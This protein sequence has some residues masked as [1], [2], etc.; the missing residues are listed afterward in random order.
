MPTCEVCHHSYSVLPG[1]LLA[2]AYSKHLL[3]CRRREYFEM[4]RIEPGRYLTPGI[5]NIKKEY[6]ISTIKPGA[7]EGIIY[8]I[9]HPRID[10][11]ILIVI[12]GLENCQVITDKLE[13]IKHCKGDQMIVWMKDE[14]VFYK[15]RKEMK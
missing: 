11:E 3:E 1:E 14:S 5:Q 12:L 7:A 2:E 13:A 4:L 15:R 10:P 8:G 9:R 6:F